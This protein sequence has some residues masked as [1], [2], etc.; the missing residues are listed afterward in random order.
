MEQERL[1]RMVGIVFRKK[2]RVAFRNV[3]GGR[4]WDSKGVILI[5][6]NKKSLSVLPSYPINTGTG[7]CSME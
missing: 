4:L 7:C 3:T 6:N 5:W 2:A 1:E